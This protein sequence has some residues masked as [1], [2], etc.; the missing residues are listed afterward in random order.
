[1]HRAEYRGSRSGGPR[2]LL[3]NSLHNASANAELPT[4]LQD[5]VTIRPKF[6]YPRLHRRFDPTPAQLSTACPC[7]SETCVHPFPNDPTLELSLQNRW[8]WTGNFAGFPYGRNRTELRA[9]LGL[10][11]V[12]AGPRRRFRNVN[13]SS[14]GI[15]QHAAAFAIASLSPSHLLHTE[16]ARSK[17]CTILLGDSDS[18]R[19]MVFDPFERTIRHTLRKVAKQRI[20]M[21]LQPG[22]YWV[23]EQAVGTDPE[24]HAALLTCYM[25]GW[26]EP[27]E[28]AIPSAAIPA[29]GNLPPNFQFEGRETLYRLTSA[30]WSAIHRSSLIAIC[31]LLISALSFATAIIGRLPATPTQRAGAGTTGQTTSTDSARNSAKE[32]ARLPV[33]PFQYAI[34]PNRF[35][36]L[37]DIPDLHLIYR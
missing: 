30:G 12:K 20:R 26:V 25:R 8:F 10:V 1:M 32:T 18:F 34:I 27:L 15:Q 7:A 3:E 16:P 22:N 35:R 29:D 23:I 19:G 28:D 37:T 11:C 2:L 36:S 17:D 31:A 13:R 6:E 33:R 21:V 14:V 4:D 5:A 24:T 9:W